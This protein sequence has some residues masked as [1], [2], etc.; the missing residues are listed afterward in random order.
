MMPLAALAGALR[1]L[2]LNPLFFNRKGR[3]GKSPNSPRCRYKTPATGC[4]SVSL[5]YVTDLLCYNYP[6]V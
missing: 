5:A 1:P 2:R 6:P 3:K 4:G